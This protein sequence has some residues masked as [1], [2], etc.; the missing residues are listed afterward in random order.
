MSNILRGT[1]V[2]PEVIRGKSAYEI[3]VM[4]GFE[5]T[6]EE[7]LESLAAKAIVDKEYVDRFE[8]VAERAEESVTISEGSAS[9][10]A[11]SANSAQQSANNATLSEESAES[12]AQRA[13]EAA[14]RAEAGKSDG[15]SA[16]H[17]WNGTVLTITSAS[18][19]SSVDLK[20][21]KGDKGETGATGA[22]GDT[23]D[24]FH[25]SKVYSSVADMNA[26][27]ATDGLPIGSFVLIST[28]NVE[29][30][31]NAKLYVKAESGYS[32]LTDMSGAQGIQGTSG[33]DGADGVSP[34]VNVSKKDGV[35][36]ITITDKN[37]THSAEIND[38]KDGADGS[39]SGVSEDRVA[40]LEQQ[41]A[42]LNYKEI[43]ISSF[44]VNPSILEIGSYASELAFKWATNKTPT[45]L[46]FDGET[47]D[48]SA[49]AKTLTGIFSS[50]D[51]DRTFTLKATDERDAVATK[52]ATL[53]CYH[54]VYYGTAPSVDEWN[55]WLIEKEGMGDA[56]PVSYM[57]WNYFTK[58]LRG[59]KLPSF[60]VNAG[61]GEYIYYALPVEMGTCSF[62]VNGFEGGFSLV[63]T[64][65]FS[66]RYGREH[67]YYLY[68]SDNASL[69]ATTVTVT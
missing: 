54:G 55:D 34:T 4:H 46:T 8:E 17:S 56:N 65:T 26:S 30:A 69:G 1:I 44:T 41:V 62:K 6:E 48:A 57:I 40:A 10:A 27:F 3:A 36:T 60:S 49:T 21:E 39:G 67:Q 37:G 47:I 31:D 20:G 59:S 7:W 68:R 50:D 18:G 58:T 61:E 11:A 19:T 42:D 12:A 2:N 28:G 43:A 29:D 16:T 63:D 22:K 5:G 13:E 52:T 38:G 15:V 64:I 51:G 33:K 66:N 35:T 25:I 23:G 24:G 9:S 45:A 14:E 32:Y 53:R